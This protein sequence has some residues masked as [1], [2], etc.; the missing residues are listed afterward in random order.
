MDFFV[1]GDTEVQP[2]RI[3]VPPSNDDPEV[4]P[5]K[6]SAYITLC[7]VLFNPSFNL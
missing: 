4:W 1:C 7:K 6:N 5:I 3:R 2:G